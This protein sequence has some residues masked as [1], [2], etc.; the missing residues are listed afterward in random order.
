VFF[1]LLEL[2][3]EEERQPSRL[4][5]SRTRLN[6]DGMVTGYCRALPVV[7]PTATTTPTECLLLECGAARGG[8]AAAE[9]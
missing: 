4:N 7:K 6:V 9:F 3:E 8:A 5:C 1:L 2:E